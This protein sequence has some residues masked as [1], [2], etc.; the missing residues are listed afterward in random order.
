MSRCHGTAADA[1]LAASGRGVRLWVQDGSLRFAGP[2]GALDEALRASLAAVRSELVAVLPGP[3]G[4]EDEWH[5]LS[6]TQQGLWFFDRLAPGCPAYHLPFAASV[7]GPFDPDGFVHRLERAIDRHA[8]LRTTFPVVDG[9]PVQ[10]I[11]AAAPADVVC[12]DAT[13]WSEAALARALRSLAETP[14]DLA[15]GP[16]LRLRILRRGP[17]QHVVALCLHHAVADLSS[18]S[19]LLQELIEGRD[20]AP[21]GSYA[22]FARRQRT[23]LDGPEGEQAWSHWRAALE[24]ADWDLPLPVDLRAPDGPGHAGGTHRFV[25]PSALAAALESMAAERDVTLF[26]LLLTSL[27][28][29][30]RGYCNRDDLLVG[31]P[32]SGRFERRFARTL[33]PFVDVLPL[34]LRVPHGQPVPELLGATHDHV[35]RALAHAD[36]PFATLVRR[37]APPRDPHRT[38][39][40]RVLFAWQSLAPGTPPAHRELVAGERGRPVQ[41]GAALWTPRGLDTGAVAFDLAATASRSQ[42]GIVVAIEHRSDLFEPATIERMAQNWRGLLEDIAAGQGAPRVVREAERAALLGPLARGPGVRSAAEGEDSA[43]VFGRFAARVREAPGRLAYLGG[44]GRM[45]YGELA[46]R[47]ASVAAAL[48]A[49]ERV[50]LLAG[51]GRD[52]LAGLLGILQAG[53]AFVP[54]AEGDPISR[55]AAMLDDAEVDTIVAAPDLWASA[56]ATG[57]RVVVT[58]R[59]G[60]AHGRRAPLTSPPRGGQALVYVAF[61]SGSTGRPKGVPITEANLAP[62]LDWGIGDLGLGPG[63]R[64]LQNLSVAFD[65]GI[66]EVLTTLLSGATLCVPG[67]GRSLDRTL[68]FLAEH[69]I[70]TLH[71]TPSWARLLLSAGRPLP[72]LRTAHFGGEVLPLDLVEPLLLAMHPDGAVFNG[73]GPTEATINC[74]VARFDR[75]SVGALRRSP[76]VPIGVPLWPFRLYVLDAAGEPAPLAG[77]GELHIGGPSV[78]SGYVGRSQDPAFRP[79][80]FE[81]GGRLYRTGDVARMMPSG[82][83]LFCGRRDQQVQLRGRRVELEEVEAAL[84][85]HPGVTGVA[86]D[87]RPGPGGA[88]LVAWVVLDDER[89]GEAELRAHA[90]ALLPTALLPSRIVPTPSLPRSPAGKLDRAA[91]PNPAPPAEPRAEARSLPPDPLDAAVLAAFRELLREPGVAADTDFFELGDSLLAV[92]LAHRLGRLLDRDVPGNALFSASTPRALAALLRAPVSPGLVV[93]RSQGARTPLFVLPPGDFELPALRGLAERLS[94]EQPVFALQPRDASSLPELLRIYADAVVAQQPAGPLR[95]LGYC[96]GGQIAFALARVLEARGRDVALVVLVDSPFRESR[97]GT[98]AYR[99]ARRLARGWRPAGSSKLAR[100]ARGLFLDPGVDA[101]ARLLQGHWPRPWRGRVVY[102]M[103]QRSHFRLMPTRRRWQRVTSPAM[104]FAWVPGDH[105]SLLHEPHVR[106]LAARLEALLG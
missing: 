85:R 34:R 105:D 44:D 53:S 18:M 3:E 67:Q 106:R 84:L 13:G 103:A 72:T 89:P 50:G 54:L 25:V 101:H 11:R 47:A 99:G 5:P 2:P 79:D 29:L 63:R 58:S 56:E 70:D 4:K 102:L 100:H 14:F 98:I 91:L 42:A 43:G 97:L 20:E 90:A 93:F 39:T 81:P 41:L 40:L 96:V 87:L 46:E 86:V 77:R 75:R 55:R 19:L 6:G 78:A 62:V 48:P 21:T 32:V 17:Q 69:R 49:G 76:S 64:V 12:E 73:Y 57:R 10:R 71:T 36:L 23:R 52:L 24:G 38:S 59:A 68:D 1:L 65:F 45:T 88:R 15:E 104:D 37:V 31:S 94:A 22:A 27:G 16:L 7:D 95:L 66:F 35:V 26:S 83:L 8:I 60:D 61:T 80:P 33:G 74:T 92:E 28:L 30:L 9:A 82:E 51:P